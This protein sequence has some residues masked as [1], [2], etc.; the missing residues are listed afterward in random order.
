[1]LSFKKYNCTG[2]Y[3]TFIYYREYNSFYIQYM[4]SGY[5]GEEPEVL[6]ET[7]HTNLGEV[8][9]EDVLDR[10]SQYSTLIYNHMIQECEKDSTTPIHIQQKV[11]FNMIQFIQS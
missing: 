2:T 6:S 7:F 1:M 5:T 8:P 11:K 3:E 10:A 9:D 4:Y